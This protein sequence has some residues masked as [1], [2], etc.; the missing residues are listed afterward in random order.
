MRSVRDIH[1]DLTSAIDLVL[2]DLTIGVDVSDFQVFRR[3]NV[4]DDGTLLRQFCCVKPHKPLL[5]SLSRTL[6]A[7][8]EVLDLD[9]VA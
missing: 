2:T 5:R 6:S 3:D 9:L 4:Q 1:R 8:F 7:A